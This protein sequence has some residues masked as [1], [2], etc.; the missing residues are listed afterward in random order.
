MT[1]QAEE[2]YQLSWYWSCA[3]EE[4]L[5]MKKDCASLVAQKVRSWP[6]MQ[7]TW[8]WSLD[9]EDPLEKD[10]ATHFSILLHGE[11]RGQGS[12]AGYSPWNHIESDT[13]EQLT[14]TYMKK[15]L[16]GWGRSGVTQ[17]WCFQMFG[18]LN[19][20]LPP[21]SWVLRVSLAVCEAAIANFLWQ[22]LIQHELRWK[23]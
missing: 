2:R 12:M 1:P 5:F 6:A 15:E 23:H 22:R 3:L 4:L 8:V 19:K 17:S 13:T 21:L 7:E 20:K 10:M 9:L 11:F 16:G 14:H 18:R